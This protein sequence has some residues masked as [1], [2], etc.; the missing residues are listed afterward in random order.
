MIKTVSIYNRSVAGWVAMQDV[1]EGLKRD[2]IER[3]V[4][5]LS[6]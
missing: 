2:G 5:H 3:F 4:F 1:R 6:I